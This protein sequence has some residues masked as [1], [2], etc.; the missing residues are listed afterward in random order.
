MGTAPKFRNCITG[1]SK[2]KD[3]KFTGRTK[4]EY[5]QTCSRYHA[6]LIDAPLI[7]TA[8]PGVNRARGAGQDR[9]ANVDFVRNVQ[10]VF[11]QSCYSCH[12]PA[13]D[14]RV[15]TRPPQRR[16]A[17]RHS[18]ARRHSPGQQRVERCFSA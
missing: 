6:P 7:G 10:P 12:G 15:Q 5:T 2:A 17:R 14:E 18:H 8:G 4:I 11:R 16:N 1:N 3:T 9:T 13:A